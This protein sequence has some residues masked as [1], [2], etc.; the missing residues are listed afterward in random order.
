[1]LILVIKHGWKIPEMN[2]TFDWGRSPEFLWFIFQQA[3]FDY[4][5]VILKDVE[6]TWSWGYPFFARYMP[7]QHWKDWRNGWKLHA[8]DILN[9][10]HA[11]SPKIHQIVR[12]LR[13]KHAHRKAQIACH[14]HLDLPA[15][16]H[17][18][19]RFGTHPRE[20][21]SYWAKKQKMCRDID[22]HRTC[23]HTRSSTTIAVEPSLYSSKKNRRS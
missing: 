17:K 4:Q 9:G 1:M 12:E 20:F 21:L 14:R 23:S 8:V 11:A 10:R 2:G 22:T 7:P 18:C 15:R 6:T 3:M 16:T 5:R 13:F 19:W